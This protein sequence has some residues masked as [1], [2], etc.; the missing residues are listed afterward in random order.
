[1]KTTLE[2]ID[3]SMQ[4]LSYHFDLKFDSS[5]VQAIV[6]HFH[7]KDQFLK[8]S[9]KRMKETQTFEDELKEATELNSILITQNQD[10]VAKLTKETRL[11]DSNFSMPF[12]MNL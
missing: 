12:I 3:V 8:V 4:I 5:S 11:K 2:L 10:L 1:M 9:I 7:G 6:K